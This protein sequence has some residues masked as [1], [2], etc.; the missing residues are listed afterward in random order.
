MTED[1]GEYDEWEPAGGGAAS[2]F[3][4]MYYYSPPRAEE[5]KFSFTGRGVVEG[6]KHF[7]E[8]KPPIQQMPAAPTTEK[9]LGALEPLRVFIDDDEED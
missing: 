7:A 5:K 6:R 8:L 3:D 1:Y 2:D 9:K 4:F